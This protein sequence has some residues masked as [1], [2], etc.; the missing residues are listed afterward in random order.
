MMSQTNK[1]VAIGVGVG[2]PLAIIVPAIIWIIILK[3]KRKGNS[4]PPTTKESNNDLERQRETTTTKKS[5]QNASSNQLIKNIKDD[6]DFDD[7]NKVTNEDI[8][9]QNDT[10]HELVDQEIENSRGVDK[11]EI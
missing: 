5:T 3:T 8:K 2:I 1:N 6:P 4:K 9:P 7:I 10:K 11:S